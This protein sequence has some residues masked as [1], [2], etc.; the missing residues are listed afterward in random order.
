MK[1]GANYSLLAKT[2]GFWFFQIS[3]WAVFYFQQYIQYYDELKEIQNMFR[4]TLSML[5]L[6]VITLV[7]RIVYRKIFIRR[8]GFILLAISGLL[9]SF[10]SAVIWALFNTFLLE[11]IVEFLTGWDVVVFKPESLS[12]FLNRTF[13][14]TFP[15]VI[16]SLLYF[17]IKFWLDLLR[18]KKRSQ[19]AALLAQ[20]SQLKMLRYQLNP[21]FLFNSLNSIQAL[22][23]E[24]P[25]NA[26]RMI[27]QL[28]DFLRYTIRDKDTLFIPLREE[29]IIVE[30]YLSIEKVRFP[31]RL[32]YE[33]NVTS[34]ASEVEVLAFI[35]QP[36]VE[37]AVKYGMRA[38]PDSLKIMV[39]GILRDRLLILEVINNGTWSESDNEGTGI[40]NVF[41]RLQNAFPDRYKLNI[42][43]TE[44]IVHVTIE[45]QTEE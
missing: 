39:N 28:S 14:L 30:K 25:A 1:G 9:L 31:D 17:G 35:L 8:P 10:F 6:F 33:I 18:E 37:N 44:G 29:V 16:W 26:D 7:L 32:N 22:I 21:H 19:E 11:H 40:R 34:E 38:S 20:K 13:F 5:F 41:E 43:K 45:I 36:F 23:Y 27:S 24:D 3:G 12:S 2:P 15:V 4:W 42:E